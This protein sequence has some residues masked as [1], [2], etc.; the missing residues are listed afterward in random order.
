MSSPELEPLGNDTSFLIF[1]EQF[2]RKIK[3]E[4]L[5]EYQHS[6]FPYVLKEGENILYLHPSCVSSSFLS[7]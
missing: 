6:S 3:M 7:N 1:Y 4:F 2:T 5:L